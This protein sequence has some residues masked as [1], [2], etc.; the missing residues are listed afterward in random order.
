MRSAKIPSCV[1]DFI[2]QTTNAP[3]PVQ[4]KYDE[5]RDSILNGDVLMYRGKSL[6]SRLICWFTRSRYSH[7][8]LAVWWNER[9]MVM[10]AIGNGVVVTPLSNNVAA[11]DGRVEWFTSVD[12]ISANDRITM[13]Q[14]AQQELGKEYD[15]W[16]LIQFA[17]MLIFGGSVEKRDKLRRS[18]KLVCSY[19]VAQAYNSI[20]RDLKPNVSDR[21][22]TPDDIANSPKLK[23]MVALRKKAKPGTLHFMLK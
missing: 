15:T 6:I 3:A 2:M 4:Q 13:V 20:G 16:K 22:M 9:L 11:Y 14:F 8:G 5:V 10:E 21:F 17:L 18:R 7:A 12:E 1:K 19:Y 23:R